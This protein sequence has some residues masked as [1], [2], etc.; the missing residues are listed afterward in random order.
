MSGAYIASDMWEPVFDFEMTP[1]LVAD[2]FEPARKFAQEVL[3]YRWMTNNA[4]VKGVVKG[5][6]NPLGL[7][8]KSRFVFNTELND[9]IYCVESPD[10]IEPVGT[11]AY[12]VFRYAE[13]NISAGVA[14]QGDYKTVIL[15]FPV[16]TLD[17]QE[18]IDCL[19]GEV[20]RFFKR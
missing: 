12:S 15:G 18:Q 7:P 8:Y 13:N 10:G 2:Y 9:Q 5:I 16:E 3:H 20:A 1:A 11:G 19:I 17:T 4:S 6:Q 14:F